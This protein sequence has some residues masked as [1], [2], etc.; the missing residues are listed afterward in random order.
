MALFPLG[1]L[2]AAGAGADLGSYELIETQILGSSTPSITFS[3]LGTYSATYK[4]L[5]I[6]MTTRTTRGGDGDYLVMRFNGV[7]TTS[8]SRH[9]LYGTGSSVLSFGLSGVTA[10]AL[11]DTPSADS[12][13]NYFGASVID[14]LDPYSTT[15]NTT[16][17]AL[18]GG[19]SSGQK[20]IALF[21]GAYYSTDAISSITLLSGNAANLGTGSRFSLYGIRG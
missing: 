4:H 3:S 6:R 8:Y 18:G 20:Q 21:S 15:K 1:I 9:Q 17:R 2:S 12:T 5:Q 7:S 10:I 16:A 19:S 11:P 14:I 13:A